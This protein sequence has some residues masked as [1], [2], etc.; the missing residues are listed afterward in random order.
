MAID[1]GIGMI[2]WFTLTKD[3]MTG[4][5]VGVCAGYCQRPRS[6]CG[7]GLNK[8]FTLARSKMEDTKFGIPQTNMTPRLAKFSI[9]L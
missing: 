2:K 3:K 6:G 5:V 4:T 7:I 1:C 8:W 9:W